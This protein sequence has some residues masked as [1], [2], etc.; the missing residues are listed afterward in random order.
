MNRRA[1]VALVSLGLLAC[2][3]SGTCIVT[4]DPSH[5][6]CIVNPNK[7]A[8]SHYKPSEFFAE[9]SVAGTMRCKAAGFEGKETS[10]PKAVQT[11]IRWKKK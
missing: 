9:D 6:Q 2:N 8:C 1:L 3:P 11:Y 4:D 5:D 10:D 7:N